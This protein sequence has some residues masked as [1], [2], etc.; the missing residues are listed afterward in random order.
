M[1]FFLWVVLIH[2]HD[3]CVYRLLVATV[4]ASRAGFR[5][6]PR[7]TQGCVTPCCGLLVVVRSLCLVVLFF[8]ECL[9]LSGG[10]LL[11]VVGC[12]LLCDCYVWLYWFLKNDSIMRECVTLCCRLLVIVR[13]LRL[14]ILVF[15]ECLKLCGGVLLFVV[16][17]WLMR[18]HYDWL[19]LP[20]VLLVIL[21]SWLLLGCLGYIEK[22]FPFSYFLVVSLL[23]DVLCFCSCGWRCC[24]LGCLK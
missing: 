21:V 19:Y 3:V 15:E 10:V 1:P 8:E 6:V 23:S 7:T 14:V 13:P 2:I 4:T 20:S 17:C 24:I 9:E 16:G 12:L 5:R 18:N 22:V 11:S